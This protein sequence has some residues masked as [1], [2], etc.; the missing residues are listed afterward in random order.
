MLTVTTTPWSVQRPIP[1]TPAPAVTIQ[2]AAWSARRSGTNFADGGDCAT[3]HGSAWD[4][5]HPTT[6]FNH[7]GL[8][9][10]GATG[11]ADCHDDTLISAA[12]ETH[13]ACTSCHDAAT[14]ALIGSAIGQTSRS[15]ATVPP[16]IAAPGKLCIRPTT[17]TIAACYGWCVRLCELPR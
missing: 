15:V 3:C 14:G 5:V 17:S 16:V 6:N 10:V 9:T 13:N 1:T 4:A 12:A 8:V 7:G 11:C 2:T